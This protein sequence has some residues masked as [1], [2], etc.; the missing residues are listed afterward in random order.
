MP[1][2]RKFLYLIIRDGRIIGMTRSKKIAE[3][4]CKQLF[5]ENCSYKLSA[6]M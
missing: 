2:K 6:V 3:Q 5:P 4:T 1:L